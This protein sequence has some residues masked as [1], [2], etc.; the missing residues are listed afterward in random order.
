VE[1][2]CKDINLSQKFLS[3][4]KKKVKRERSQKSKRK[5]KMKKPKAVIC[6]PSFE[7]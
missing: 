4:K 3:Q 5:V 7:F 1:F 2:G 6:S